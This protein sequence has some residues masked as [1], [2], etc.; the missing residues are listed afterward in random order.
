[1]PRL[2]GASIRVVHLEMVRPFRTSF[3]E[4]LVREV[5]VLD[6][7]FGDTRTFGEAAA[8]A[9]P[10]YSAEY[11]RDVVEC[12]RSHLLPRIMD[13]ELE[14][15]EALEA[16]LAPVRGHEMAKSAVVGAWTVAWAA[17]LGVSMAHLL[18]SERDLIPCGISLGIY[19][20]T[21]ELEAAVEASLTAGF[22]RVKLKIGPGWDVDAVT[23]VRRSFPDLMLT[24]D[25]NASYRRED[26]E[27][28][29]KLDNFDL[30]FIEQPLPEDDL[31]GHAI[32]QE[33]IG[34]SI[35]LDESIVSS[36]TLQTAIRL[37]AARV[38]NLKVGRV[39]GVWATKRM[40]DTCV[41]EGIPV[42]CGGLMESAIGQGEGLV[43]ASLPGFQFPAD[44][45]PSERYFARDLSTIGPLVDGHIAVPSGVGQP[46]TLDEDFL[47]RATVELVK[48][49]SSD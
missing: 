48:V 5:V 44:I 2:T 36:G 31:I 1:M 23:A 22:V 26:I 45:G 7:T 25:G 14:S 21:D 40:H 4:V 13:R 10:V 43:V 16:L 6:A 42:W 15:P 37:G 39:G 8:L 9:A 47:E 3:G 32:L 18:G 20:T 38:V 41:S 28:L 12:L 30:A 46:V 24:V 35:C 11:T 49:S 27:H 17:E 29:T 33:H 34:T 19:R